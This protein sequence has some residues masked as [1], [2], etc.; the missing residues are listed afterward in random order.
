MVYVR[1]N[2]NLVNYS[3]VYLK[4]F[5][6]LVTNF[7]YEMIGRIFFLG[8]CYRYY[9]IL[10]MGIFFFLSV[11]GSIFVKGSNGVF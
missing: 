6:L 9:I 11:G 10:I 2:Y 8:I 5:V 7:I 3:S 1:W 4:F